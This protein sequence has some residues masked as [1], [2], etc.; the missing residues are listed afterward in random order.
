MID[1]NWTEIKAEYVA[2]G[3]SQ[4]K[5]AKKYGISE[6]TLITRANKENWN[7]ERQKAENKAIMKAQQ[8]AAD[9]I[10][11]NA[12][13]AQRIKQKLLKKLEKEIDELPEHIGTEKFNEVIKK[14]KDGSK[15]VSGIKYK[16]NE[17]AQSYKL[18]VGDLPD[19]TDTAEQEDDSLTLS[20]KEFAETLEGGEK[21][22]D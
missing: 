3:I 19:M 20:L 16:I 10:A 5:L 6:Y 17:L 4:R 7:K 1:V 12:I 9:T 13:I 15:N 14:G 11:D 2:G 18:L 21:D 8:K 22:A